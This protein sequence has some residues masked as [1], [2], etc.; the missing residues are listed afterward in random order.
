MTESKSKKNT[1][2]RPT[3]GKSYVKEAYNPKA[4]TKARTDKPSVVRQYKDAAYN[5]RGI[6]RARTQNSGKSS[7]KTS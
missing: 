4:I 5:P 2:T 1:I 7:K 6:T 3:S